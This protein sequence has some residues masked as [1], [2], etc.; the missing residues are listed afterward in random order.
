MRLLIVSGAR[1]VHTRRWA[2]ALAARGHEVYILSESLDPVPGTRL[3]W[4]KTPRWGFHYPQRWFGR[5]RAY[6]R[7]VV[8]YVRPDLV[9]IHYLSPY[10]F[11]PK[12]LLGAP[13]VISVWGNDVVVEDEGGEDDAVRLLEAADRITATTHFLAG[14]CSRYAGI[15]E[16]GIVVIPFGVEVERFEEARRRRPPGTGVL[17]IGF[18]KH[19]LPKYGPEYLLRAVPRMTERFPTVKVVMVGGGYLEDDLRKLSVDLG[20]A[21]RVEWVGRVPYERIPDIQAGLDVFV[22]PSVCRESFG[23][24]AI[25]AQAAG[26]PV[27]ASDF[28]GVREAVQD[29]VGGILVQPRDSGAI[30]EAVSRLLA[31]PELRRSMGAAGNRYVRERFV[32]DDNVTAMEAL[33]RRVLADGGRRGENP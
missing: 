9:H 11:H 4:F 25:E 33:Y 22:M 14:A 20:I 26:V 3:I 27:V 10:Y 19:L 12:D 30:A 15:P 5:Y 21:D 17:R 8:R 18:V 28:P 32:W 1:M 6:V 31:D 7:D 29:G 24:S 13:L 2:Q 16:D 23:V